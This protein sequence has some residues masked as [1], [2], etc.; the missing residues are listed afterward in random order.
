M[1]FF[2][3]RVLEWVPLPSPLVPWPGIKL[4]PPALGVWSPS[5]WTTS[6]V[7]KWLLKIRHNPWLARDFCPL[8]NPANILLRASSVHFYNSFITL[9]NLE[10]ILF[11]FKFI[12]LCPTTH[13]TGSL[14]PQP[15]IEPGSSAVRVLS[16]NYWTTRGFPILAIQWFSNWRFQKH[17]ENLFKIKILDLT[18]R[19]SDSWVRCRPRNISTSFQMI[20][21]QVVW[22]VHTKN[23]TLGKAF[24]SPKPVLSF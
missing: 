7:P 18:Q 19:D 8:R 22:G 20:L 23:P 21:R 17:T 4:G 1:G 10:H 9:F 6:K 16:P 15:G 24:Y 13:F 3:A 11:F 12:Y 2:Q 14:V 5:H